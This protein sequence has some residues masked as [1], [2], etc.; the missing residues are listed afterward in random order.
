MHSSEFSFMNFP[1]DQEILIQVSYIPLFSLNFTG[2][3]NRSPAGLGA[4]VL[5]SIGRTPSNGLFDGFMFAIVDGLE[6]KFETIVSKT[7]ICQ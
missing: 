5:G 4:I 1:S 2:A 3:S 7:A 6:S